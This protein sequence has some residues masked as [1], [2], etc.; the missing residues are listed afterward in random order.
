MARKRVVASLLVL[1]SIIGTGNYAH[2]VDQDSVKAP[3]VEE[4]K[5]LELKRVDEVA[6]V[7]LNKFAEAMGTT[8]D[9]Q[10]VSAATTIEKKIEVTDNSIMIK[11]D[12]R[13]ETAGYSKAST[14][15]ILP[16]ENGPSFFSEGEVWIRVQFLERH[17]KGKYSKDVTRYMPE[18]MELKLKEETEKASL[19]GSSE[20]NADNSGIV[21]DYGESSN[22]M[23]D[24]PTET[25]VDPGY[26]YGNNINNGN[27][28]PNNDLNQGDQNGG[29]TENQTPIPPTP[30]AP[31]T[32]S[33]P[34]P[35]EST[36][37][38][39]PPTVPE[40]SGGAEGGANPVLGDEAKL[41]LE[42]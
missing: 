9:I 17:Y 6:Y 32:P 10:D 11:Y 38:S 28:Y 20:E 13:E 2:A 14:G 4:A 26:D 3:I 23:S 7:S 21:D 15:E 35:E 25:P 27:I 41:Q 33:T 31:S 29:S 8:V 34:D 30:P 12:G 5:W 37:P 19:T 39:T 36:E 16:Q 24:Y 40:N 22:D 18:I 42:N 1:A